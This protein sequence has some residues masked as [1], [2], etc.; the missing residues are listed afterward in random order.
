[1]NH[2]VQEDPLYVSG[3]RLV[4]PVLVHRK[5]SAPIWHRRVLIRRNN[6]LSGSDFQE[7]PDKEP[8]SSHELN[9]TTQTRTHFYILA[10]TTKRPH[11][12][13]LRLVLKCGLSF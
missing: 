1:A 9:P 5:T 11:A 3:T 7:S 2:Q 8:A 12:L 4:C 13:P 10:R 6:Q